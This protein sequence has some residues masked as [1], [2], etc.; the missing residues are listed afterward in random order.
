MLLR[1]VLGYHGLICL[2]NVIII[3]II[4]K[5]LF[6]YSLSNYRF[7]LFHCRYLMEVKEEAYYN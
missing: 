4:F 6:V 1:F 7:F 3:S 5:A 2:G